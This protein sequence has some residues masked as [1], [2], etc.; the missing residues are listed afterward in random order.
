MTQVGGNSVTNTLVTSGV[1][2]TA[3]KNLKS[4]TNLYILNPS[5]TNNGNI[6]NS[7]NNQSNNQSNTNSMITA[8]A[9]SVVHA[10][11]LATMSSTTQNNI[12]NSIVTTS[13]ITTSTASNIPTDEKIG[14]RRSVRAS[15]AANKIIYSR[16]NAA[17]AAAAAASIA[18]QTLLDHKPASIKNVSLD[19]AAEV[20]RKTRRAGKV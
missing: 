4:S 14:T 8:S 3:V 18:A 15:A 12:N 7:N 16:G 20:R 6:N 5:N 19:S 17:A 9:T 13:T 10:T 1:V 11:R 2:Q